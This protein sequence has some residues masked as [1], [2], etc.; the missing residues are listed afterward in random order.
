LRSREHPKTICPSEVARSLNTKDFESAGA[1]AGSW[2][3]AMPQ[4][5]K[6]VAEMRS[7]GE[8]EVLQEGAVLA[9]LASGNLPIPQP[10]LGSFSLE[11]VF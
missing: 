1:G 10:I 2:R 5:R 7:R 6:L 9:D 3:E 11:F 8:A 4:V